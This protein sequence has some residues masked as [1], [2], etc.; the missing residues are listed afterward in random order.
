MGPT[1]LK[2]LAKVNPG[3]AQFAMVS[4]QFS[5]VV[6]ILNTRKHR[7]TNCGTTGSQVDTTVDNWGNT[8]FTVVKMGHAVLHCDDTMVE[9]GKKRLGLHWGT[10]L[11]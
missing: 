6:I 7:D 5:T 1:G 10:Q 11:L 3:L 9:L 2:G 8:G 4:P